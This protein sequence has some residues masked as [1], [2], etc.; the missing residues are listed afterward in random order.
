[1][2]IV[3][4]GKKEFLKSLTSAAVK[5]LVGVCRIAVLSAWL[6]LYEATVTLCFAKTNF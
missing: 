3:G 5:L 4:Q 6:H 1:M 2:V